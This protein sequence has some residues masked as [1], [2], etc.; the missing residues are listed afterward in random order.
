M[1]SGFHRLGE[2][3]A[4]EAERRAQGGE[5]VALD[6]RLVVQVLAEIRAV[7]R[8]DVATEHRVLA[9]NGSLVSEEGD[10]SAIRL[11][12]VIRQAEC[13]QDVGHICRRLEWSAVVRDGVIP[14]GD[15][16]TVIDRSE[17]A[18]PTWSR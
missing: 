12:P 16:L 2:V 6:H 7:D 1:M 4:A 9:A 14:E 17:I 3:F 8:H 10:G 13:P 5:G 11:A 15:D 18:I